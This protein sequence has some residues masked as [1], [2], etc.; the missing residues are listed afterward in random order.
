MTETELAE[1]SNLEV[2]L[3]RHN[4][5]AAHFLD[6]GRAGDFG[7]SRQAI[8]IVDWR[9]RILT[10]KTDRTPFQQCRLGISFIGPLGQPGLFDLANCR[11]AQADNFD[12]V[13]KA[14]SKSLL[15]RPM[16]QVR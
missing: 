1:L 5:D 3:V 8:A 7:A 4:G 12:L 13:G 9:R 2:P 10:G 16:E 15:V 14:I 11:D 6:D